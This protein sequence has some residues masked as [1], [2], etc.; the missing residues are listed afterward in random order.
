MEDP[1][2]K[3]ELNTVDF[4]PLTYT[5]CK[6]SHARKM[7]ENYRHFNPLA[8]T[9]C[10]FRTIIRILSFQIHFNPLT[11]TD[12]KSRESIPGP[13]RS[14]TFSFANLILKALPKRYTDQLR[15]IMV[16]RWT[17]FLPGFCRA[18]PVISASALLSLG[19]SKRTQLCCYPIL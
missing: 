6:S 11:Y 3:N 5:D 2:K 1:I 19:R 15:T 13:V 10:K 8:Y 9:D 16:S 17:Y 18:V 12:C 4:N 7:T 14:Y